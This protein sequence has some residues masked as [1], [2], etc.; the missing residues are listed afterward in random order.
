MDGG[1]SKT[2]V[3]RVFRRYPHFRYHRSDYCTTTRGA[4]KYGAVEM[5]FSFLDHKPIGFDMDKNV[6]R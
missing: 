4:A 1:S 2:A 5:Q 3:R 6:F